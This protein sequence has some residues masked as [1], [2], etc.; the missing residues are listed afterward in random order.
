MSNWH[1]V[2]SKQLLKALIRKGWTIKRI[3]GSHKILEHPIHN[4]YVFAFHDN[5]E[6]DPKMLSRISKHIGIMPEDL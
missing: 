2:K 5:E 3:S 4:D 1:S 6:I